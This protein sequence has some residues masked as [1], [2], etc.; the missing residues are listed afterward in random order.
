MKYLAKLSFFVMM[1]FAG[2][3]VAACGDDDPVTPP[4]GDNNG[5]ENG[6]NGGG[7]TFVYAEPYHVWGS[8]MAQV[9]SNMS[10]YEI[11]YE[12]D[13]N[14]ILFGNTPV[15]FYGYFFNSNGLYGLQIV[16]EA[17]SPT[18]AQVREG[19]AKK[20]QFLEYDE[21]DK[22]Y[23]YVS[24]DKKTGVGVWE[25]LDEESKPYVIVQLVGVDFVKEDGGG[26]EG[27]GDENTPSFS[28]PYLN[29]GVSLAQ[30]QAAK[31]EN[32]FDGVE[33]DEE[34]PNITYA[35]YYGVSPVNYEM[36]QFDS[37]V[38]FGSYI[39]M[40][41]KNV[42][43]FD[44]VLDI[45]KSRYTFV[46]YSEEDDVYL[47]ISP[48]YVTMVGAYEV[49]DEGTL[50]SC[51]EYYDYEYMSSGS[52]APAKAPAVKNGKK[53]HFKNVARFVPRNFVQKAPAF[54]VSSKIKGFKNIKF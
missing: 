17:E 37:N 27:G 12:G 1:L 35:G 22:T 11:G 15:K 31:D 38:L 21:E 3:A 19:L 24:E 44:N 2:F 13:V 41:S 52:S 5:G 4:S 33:V 25:E 48:D 29:W 34:D 36:Y 42:G 30:L 23:Y 6:G 14:L 39:E 18:L 49:N 47:F 7:N 45:L 28:D 43:S 50:L 32:L 54:K 20:Y 16:Y 9:K 53:T 26:D 51:V 46:T 10:D 8:S 40:K